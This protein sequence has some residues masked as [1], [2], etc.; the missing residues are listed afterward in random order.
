MV[1]VRHLLTA[2]HAALK[3]DIASAA[4]VTPPDFNPANCHFVRGGALEFFPYQ[5]LDF[6]KHFHDSNAFAFR[7]LFWWG[8]TSCVPC[9]WRERGSSSTRHGSW[10]DFISSPDRDWNYRW[11]RYWS[12][13]LMALNLPLPETIFAHGWWT[14]DGEKMSKSRGNVVDPNK[15]VDEFGVDAFRY[16]LLREVSFGQDGNFFA[17]CHDQ[18]HQWRF[19]KRAGQSA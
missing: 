4:L 13:M 8:T 7:T 3:A 16:F 6:P 10:T 5:Y 19:G 12:T 18:S 14:V 17:R 2:T 1:K 9:C 11:R 15:M